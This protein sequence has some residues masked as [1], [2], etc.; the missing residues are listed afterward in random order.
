MDELKRLIREGVY[1][2]YASK[3]HKLPEK[4]VIPAKTFVPIYHLVFTLST[5]KDY[6]R[7]Q[8]Q[9][10]RVY[11]AEL[12]EFMKHVIVPH[13]SCS[14]VNDH[15]P[16]HT[17]PPPLHRLVME[18]VD[19]THDAK[20]VWDGFVERLSAMYGYLDRFYTHNYVLSTTQ[21]PNV[22]WSNTPSGTPTLWTKTCQVLGIDNKL[23]AHET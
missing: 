7:M 1:N 11:Y 15:I 2:V 4:T 8:E 9:M 22:V 10:Y 17:L 20:K 23:L 3:M 21:L 16:P 19:P 6:G 13:L 18:Y 14:C 5:Q 12:N